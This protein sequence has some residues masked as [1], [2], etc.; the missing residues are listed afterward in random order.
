M[1]KPSEKPIK[2]RYVKISFHYSEKPEKLL[3]PFVKLIKRKGVE[4]GVITFHEGY[5]KYVTNRR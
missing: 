2:Y 3:K 4:G 5:T 1:R